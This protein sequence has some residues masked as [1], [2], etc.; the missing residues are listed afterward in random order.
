MGPQTSPDHPRFLALSDAYST[1]LRRLLFLAAHQLSISK[2]ALAEGTY[3]W[4]SGPN[5]ETPAEG[6]FLRSIG[7]D[8]VGMS[9]VPEVLIAREEGLKVMVL[10]LVT[11]LVVIP[12]SYKSIREEVE[13][14]V[15][16]FQMIILSNYD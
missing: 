6:I 5:Y 1:S 11:N 14:E 13:A 4:V 7:V 15:Y 16:I 2:S 10:S 9:T 12:P 3:A 8:V